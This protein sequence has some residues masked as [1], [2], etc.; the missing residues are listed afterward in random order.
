MSHHAP[1][2]HHQSSN[3]LR[4]SLQNKNQK[5]ESF[6]E[7]FGLFLVNTKSPNPLLF[8]RKISPQDLLLRV[9][10]K[11]LASAPLRKDSGA[12][13]DRFRLCFARNGEIDQLIRARG[14]FHS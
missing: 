4:K 13:E 2:T 11:A 14:V 10:T 3:D 6:K 5:L 7:E 1:I 9:Y 12:P 8:I